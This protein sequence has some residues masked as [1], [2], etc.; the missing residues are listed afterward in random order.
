MAAKKYI[1]TGTGNELFEEKSATIVSA[2][3]GNEGDLVALD[4]G[5]KLDVSVLPSGI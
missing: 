3:A 4:A 1:Q 5:G 2:G